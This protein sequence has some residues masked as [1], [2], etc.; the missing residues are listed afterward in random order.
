MPSLLKRLIPLL[1]LLS[2]LSAHAN[3]FDWRNYNLEKASRIQQL[4]SSAIQSSPWGIQFN[5]M[6]FH[7]GTSACWEALDLEQLKSDLPVLIEKTVGLGVK[8]VRISIDWPLIEDDSGN[9][10]WDLLDPMVRGLTEAGIEVY[11]SL[12]GGHN[13][14]TKGKAPIGEAERTAWLNYAEKVARRYGD[15]IDYY[16]IWNE[17]NTVWFWPRPVKPEDYFLLVK[18][19]SK[20]LK[21]VD[22]GCKVIGGSLARIDVPYATRLF[23]LGIADYIDVLCY[24][25]YGTFPESALKKINVQVAPPTL[26]ADVGHRAAD[27]QA[28]IDGSGREIDLWQGECGYP[29]AMNSLGWTGLGPF[30][31]SV[32][33]KWILRRG[34]TDLA[35]GASVSAFF[36]LK[37]FMNA[38]GDRMN[39]KGLLDLG[40]NPKKAYSV[41]QKLCSAVQGEVELVTSESVTINI[42]DAGGMP[43]ITAGNVRS[44]ILESDN[45]RYIAYWAETHLQETTLPGSATLVL[46]LVQSRGDTQLIDPFNGHNHRVTDQSVNENQLIIENLPLCDFPFVLKLDLGN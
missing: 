44:V 34:M 12:H 5:G 2:S 20:L 42:E 26:Y 39:H 21:K 38:R 9:F 33:A 29:S 22:P 37:D 30:G 4:D 32:Q 18:E 23:E 35:S 46:P 28:L 11:L 1:I 6:P 40:N 24:H 7:D 19:A 15:K 36:I 27:L 25:P 3:T 10:H 8:W 31:E 41:L 43:G 16:E 17:P 13:S 14:H 45:T